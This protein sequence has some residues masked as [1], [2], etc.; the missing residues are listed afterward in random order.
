MV[1]RTQGGEDVP[2]VIT[3]GISWLGWSNLEAVPPQD[4]NLYPLKLTHLYFELPYDRDDFGVFLI[5]KLEAFY[6]TSED[7]AAN[8]APA[9]FFYKVEPGDTVTS[10]SRKVYG[11][12]DYKNEIMKNNSLTSGDGLTVG[13]V[14]VLIRR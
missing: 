5:D 7:K 12:I 8:D 13:R 4:L 14:L 10:I 1:F 6:P 2:I 11:T 9:N 3:E